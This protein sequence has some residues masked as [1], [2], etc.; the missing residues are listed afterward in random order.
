MKRTLTYTFLLLTLLAIDVPDGSAQEKR[1]R[2]LRLGV[3]VSGLVWQYVEPQSFSVAISA[4]Y[5]IMPAIYM[6]A[7]AGRLKVDRNKSNFN[8]T[9]EGYYARLGADY[10]FIQNDVDPTAKYDM[11]YGGIRFSGARY[12][13]QAENI[14]FQND[15]WGDYQSG[16][17]PR[18][19][20]GAYWVELVAGLRVEALKNFFIGWSVRGQFMLS[21][22]NDK[23]I[24]TWMIPGYGKADQ[25]TGLS[26]TYSLS[27]R[28]PL[29]RVP[30]QPPAF[31]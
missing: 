7:E 28:I 12:S 29:T 2:G 26:F 5:E 20:M 4:D 16:S 22:D 23:R 10:N 27:Y 30:E 13:H 31:F 8:Y 3:D 24:E 1:I 17:M 18:S 9:A 25:N 21:R 11:L 6:A 14:T 15:Y 19:N